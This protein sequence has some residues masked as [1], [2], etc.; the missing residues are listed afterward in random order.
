MSYQ[1]HPLFLEG[2]FIYLQGIQP[3]YS[4]PYR[5]GR[6]LR[7]RLSSKCGIFL[8]Q[9]SPLRKRAN[10]V[11][12]IACKICDACKIKLS[13]VDQ[14]AKKKKRKKKKRKKKKERKRKKKKEN[15]FQKN[16]ASRKTNAKS[17]LLS[18]LIKIFRVFI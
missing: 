2:C 10:S 15:C 8:I 12:H 7:V 5:S 3:A 13:R 11:L 9:D 14:L 6:N 18:V 4:K 17:R 1:E 16:I